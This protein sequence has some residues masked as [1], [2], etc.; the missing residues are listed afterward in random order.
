MHPSIKENKTWMILKGN[1]QIKSKI[2]ILIKEIK[3]KNIKTI[4]KTLFILIINKSI[5]KTLLAMIEWESNLEIMI[6]I[7]EVI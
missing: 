4:N 5:M 1:S 2:L 3:N 6:E 7:K